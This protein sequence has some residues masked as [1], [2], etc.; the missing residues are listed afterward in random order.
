MRALLDINVLIALHDREHVQHERAALWLESNIAH[1]WAS[2]PLTQ[3]GCLRIM[4]QP[5]YSSPQPLA[6]LIAMLQ[7]STG[8]AFHVLWS[9]DISLLDSQHFQHAHIHSH[10]QLTDL[11]LLALAVKHGGRLVSFDQ[12]IPLSA[13]PGAR[14]EHLVKL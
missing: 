9:D 1:G 6:I 10:N 8:T 13:V 4:S 7:G 2:C 5:G 11:Y 3:N 14:A 12:R